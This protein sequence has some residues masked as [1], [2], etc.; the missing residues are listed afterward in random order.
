MFAVGI[1]GLFSFLRGGSLSGSLAGALAIGQGL[2]MLQGLAGVVL[3]LDGLRP[4]GGSLHYLYGIAAALVLP[5]VWSY[6]RDRNARQALLFYSLISL[7]AAGLAI[8]GIIT[9]S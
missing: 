9:G 5:F 1:W 8:R 2:I 4:A 3:F 7:F 6:M